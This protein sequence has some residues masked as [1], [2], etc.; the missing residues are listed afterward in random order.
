MKQLHFLFSFLAVFLGLNVANAE[1]VSPYQ[2]DFD[3]SV[4]TSVKGFKA[5]PGWKHI[6]GTNT[7]E[8]STMSY[9]WS[10]T[11]GVDGSGALYAGGQTTKTYDYLVTPAVS[12]TVTLDV[13]KQ[14]SGGST[15]NFYAVTEEADGTLTVGDEIAYEGTPDVGAYNTLTLT[16]GEA[17]RIAIKATYMYMDNFTAAS[18]D[19]VLA[20]ELTINSLDEMKIGDKVITSSAGDYANCDESNNLPPVS[21]T[22]TVTNTGE[23]DLVAGE[24][25][26]SVSIVDYSNNYTVLATQ[27]V[28]VNLPVGESIQVTVVANLNYNEYPFNRNRFDVQEDLTFT[29][30][31][32]MWVETNPYISKFSFTPE[33]VSTEIESGTTVAFGKISETTTKTYA[34]RNSGAAPLQINSITAP[35]GY[36]LNVSGPLTV[37]ASSNQPLTITLPATTPGYYAGDLTISYKNNDNEDVEYTLALTGTVLDPAKWYATFDDGKFPSGTYHGANWETN[38]S[39]NYKQNASFIQNGTANSHAVTTD[40]LFVTPLLSASAGETLQFDVARRTK[41]NNDDTH[42]LAVYISNDRKNWSL[43]RKIEY[44]ELTEAQTTLTSTYYS[45]YSDFDFQ[46]FA[47]NIETAGNYYIGFDA[48][49]VRLDNIY[50]LTLVPVDHDVF[51][52]AILPTD[53]QTNHDLTIK[54]TAQNLLATAESDY[55]VKYYVDGVVAAQ[56]EAVELTQGTKKDISFTYTPYMAG[57]Y[58]TYAELE[59]I[60]GTKYTSDHVTLTVTEEQA[61]GETQIGTV[62]SASSTI[63]LTNYTSSETETVYT[64]SELSL[65]PAG[66]EI[67]SLAWIG[68][69]SATAA[70][71]HLQVYLQ[72]T[73]DEAPA[74][75]GDVSAMKLVYDGIYTHPQV[76]KGKV[77]DL[78]LSEPFTYNGGNLRVFVRS[79]YNNGS[80]YPSATSYSCSS[81][82]KTK[83]RRQD[84]VTTLTSSWN[85][86]MGNPVIVLGYDKEASTFSGVLS[87]DNADNTN[88]PI[89]GAT[90]TLTNGNTK[91]AGKTDAQGY[92]SFNVLQDDKTYDITTDYTAK[93]YFPQ[94]QEETTVTFQGQSVVK[95]ITLTEAVDFY[96]NGYEAPDKGKVGVEYTA[97]ATVTNYNKAVMEAGDYTATLYVG[98]LAVP[99]TETVNLAEM[100]E[101]TF[102][103]TFVPETDGVQTAYIQFAGPTRTIQTEEFTFTVEGVHGVTIAANLPTAGQVNHTVEAAATVTNNLDATEAADSY[104]IK[105]FVNGEAVSEATSVDLPKNSAKQFAFSFMPHATGSYTTYVELRFNDGLGTFKSEEVTL[106]IGSE[107]A[108]AEKVVV[109][110]NSVTGGYNGESAPI[111]AYNK[112]TQSE[113]IYTAQQLGISANTKITSISFKGYSTSAFTFPVKVWVA[114][115]EDTAPASSGIEAVSTDN[116]TKVFEASSVTFNG[117]SSTGLIDLTFD[118]D[119]PFT[120]DG[121]N[122]RV[123]VESTYASSYNS[124]TYFSKNT[125][126]N[127]Q[128]AWRSADSNLETKAFANTRGLPALSIGYEK[129]PSVFTGVLSMNKADN[130]NTKIGGATVTLTAEDGVSYSGET[131]PDGRYTFPVIQDNKTYTVTVANLPTTLPA[132]FPLEKTITFNGQSI[133]ENITLTEAVD[134][135]LSNLD[136]PEAGMVNH[137]LTITIDVTNYGDAKAADD[138]TATLY[139][140]GGEETE[141]VATAETVAIGEMETKTLTFHVTPYGAGTVSLYIELVT[142]N[143]SFKTDNF[144]VT[145][146]EEFTGGEITVGTKNT[147]SGVAPTALY[148]GFSLVE[149]VYTAEQLKAFGAVEGSKVK[150]ITFTAT[151]TPT[152]AGYMAKLDAWVAPTSDKAGYTAGQYNTDEMTQVL[153]G[154]YDY[155]ANIVNGA[156]TLTL[157]L[158]DSP[159]VFDGE[160]GIRIVTSKYDGSYPG[161]ISFPFDDHYKTTYTK[162]HDTKS[163]FD[164]NSLSLCNS[165]NPVAVFTFD[166]TN[167]I[168]GVVTSDGTTPMANVKVI[169]QSDN[170]IYKTYTDD[171]GKYELVVCQTDKTYTLT[172]SRNGEDTDPYVEEGLTFDNG[173]IVRDIV[174]GTYMLTLDESEFDGNLPSGLQG[175]AIVKYSAKAGW[176]TICEPF[177]LTNEILTQIFGDEYKA[178]ELVGGDNGVLTFTQP[179][180]YVA[181]MPY[182]VFCKTPVV[183]E[184]GLLVHGISIDAAHPHA[185]TYGGVTFQG[186][187]APIAAPGMEG[188]YGI[189]PTTGRIQKGSDKA[190]LKG[191]RAYFEVSDGVDPANLSFSFDDGTIITG[192]DDA[193]L[194]DNGQLTTDSAIY[195][196]R[197]RKVAEAGHAIRLPKGVYI[198]NG[199]KITVK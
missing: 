79:V 100:E 192:I 170:V 2:V 136:V 158:S 89:V 53:G 3:T 5:A 51:F 21:F 56:G 43:L 127:T 143:R 118:F 28:G 55:T 31:I 15:I 12:G 27:P 60:D 132:A 164:S 66:T 198:Q 161:N 94:S 128:V 37:D 33:G 112:G 103:F 74:A 175:E 67:K 155:N 71:S 36:Q 59:F 14:Y 85:D 38:S 99:A 194:M 91:Y 70:D 49:Y 134:F 193:T 52:T 188:L 147:T 11:T 156:Y 25:N 197:G 16:V 54:T 130:T 121:T 47:V 177:A 73:D 190:S 98:N 42:F 95:N 108:S 69:R 46:T 120:Y 64:A 26:F 105:Y 173:D 171:E 195:D 141:A 82:L 81:V 157:D 104:T 61:I 154:D 9:S 8:S 174:L 4:D 113:M 129:A 87:I 45:N 29:R 151:S 153:S 172:A 39:T 19:V 185:V 139:F 184:N 76:S 115:T 63:I 13:S 1:T 23:R 146:E 72:N 30:V 24:D 93:N 182:V 7:Y 83:Y 196:L 148:Y 20:G 150:K 41:N 78:T 32:G 35:A 123:F 62:A 101:H 106:E 58:D 125:D 96:L 186:T 160:N 18:A 135:Y 176:N 34:I 119:S 187:Y 166:N 178:Y 144:N 117:G 180:A 17:T 122:L 116:M 152:K 126:Y 181:G 65:I 22:V 107:I 189:V 179:T 142:N 68:T 92:Y 183:N 80:G 10:A 6:L 162:Q 133:E 75:D 77:I 109:E 102:S 149:M 86:V 50:G 163:T 138:Y 169:A 159:I 191:F 145:I 110:G 165:G 84:S 111:S 137:D 168:S 48:G 167:T 199:K 57:T 90:V 124:N 131:G 40:A 88:T 97:T 140:V 44:S 114:N